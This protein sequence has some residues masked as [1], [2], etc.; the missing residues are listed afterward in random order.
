[1][2]FRIVGVAARKSSVA[3]RIVVA[4]RGEDVLALRIVGV[5]ART[6]AFRKRHRSHA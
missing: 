2:R 1:M 3:F 5:T 6:T 4:A